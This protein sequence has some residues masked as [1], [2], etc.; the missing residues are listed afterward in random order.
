MKDSM[1]HQQGIAFLG[2][3]ILLLILSVLGAMV[4]NLAGQESLSASAGR[5]AAVAQQLADAAGELVIAGFHS[6][7]AVPT[8]LA[9]ALA[10]KH[11][12]AAGAPSYM[13]DAGVSQFSGTAD[14][15]DLWLH[16]SDSASDRLL[17]DPQTG[18][19]RAMLDLGKLEELKIYAPLGPGSLC[20]IDATV[21]TSTL[22]SFRQSLTMQLAALDVPALRAA[23][24]VGHNLGALQVGQESPVGV[25]WGHL[26][27]IGDAV[28]RR[29]D[30]LPIL[31][32][33]AP[34]TGRGYDETLERE[35]RWMEAWIGGEVH[36]SQPAAG[37]GQTSSWPS[38]VHPQ[39]HPI[40]GIRLEE[41]PYEQLKKV[42]KQF[43]RY[44]GID[45]DGLL[46]PQGLIHPGHGMRPDDVLRSQAVGDQQGLIFIDTLDQQAPRPDN[47]GTV[48]I[49]A[50]YVQGI[51]VVQGHVLYAPSGGQPLQVLSPPIATDSTVSRQS[52]QLS[53]VNFN[54]VLYAS[55][56]ISLAGTTRIFGA[57]VAGGTI[58]ASS[59]GGTLE[60]WYNHD[61][62]QGFYQGLPVVY[63]APGTWMMK[64]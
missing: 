57:V 42:A 2:A 63:P 27:V 25:H 64:Y 47:L 33:L 53:R 11:T 14:R 10:K 36:V 49:Q 1:Q 8:A 51:L 22:A 34:V 59:S 35:D 60:V 9:A 46:Y 61:V 32:A 43:G 16:A 26:K 40:P 41:W 15:P 21:S 17:N 31:S 37:P 58:A 29:T 44:F 48:T 56:N 19:F 3:M 38:N 54:G 18:L 6:P 62:G 7:Q 4:L 30:E 52:V 24:Q 5:D 23:V 20:T 50:G 28:F 39:Q 13:D 55:G 45:R 12:T